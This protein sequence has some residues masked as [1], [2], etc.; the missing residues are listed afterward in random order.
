MD[1]DLKERIFEAAIE[2]FNVKGLKFTMDDI[3]KQLSISKKTIYT[4]FK[5][6]NQM[7]LEMVDY[8]F[9]NIKESEQSIVEDDSLPLVEK[10]RRI[11]SIMPDSYRTIDLRQLYQLKEDYPEIYRRVEERLESG[12]EMTLELMNEGIEQGVIRDVKLP[13]FKMMMEAALEQ[14][15]SRDILVRCDMTYDEGLES[16]VDILFRGIKVDKI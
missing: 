9:D 13:L 7:F 12:W 10:I 1:N 8:L 4:Q 2:S 11:L 15:F 5:T 16:V 14:F 3:A 6:K